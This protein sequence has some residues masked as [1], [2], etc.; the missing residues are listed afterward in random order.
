MTSFDI[1]ATEDL[2]RIAFLI[3]EVPNS[4][5]AVIRATHNDVGELRIE[6]N[7]V[8]ALCMPA[9]YLNRVCIGLT[10]IK[11]SDF[12]VTAASNELLLIRSTPGNAEHR[13]RMSILA[14][15]R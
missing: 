15:D 8:D 12:R 1:V 13:I 2:H 9:Q 10:H 4:D 3:L 5:A 14:N 6:Q 11:E 7:I